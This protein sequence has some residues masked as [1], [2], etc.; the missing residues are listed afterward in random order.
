M[1]LKRPDP[2]SPRVLACGINFIQIHEEA[3]IPPTTNMKIVG[4]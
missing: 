1:V 4:V 3:S 2:E